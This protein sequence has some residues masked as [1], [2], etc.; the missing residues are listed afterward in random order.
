MDVMNL[1]GSL[2]YYV[3][4]R[5]YLLTLFTFVASFN[6]DNYTFRC[7]PLQSSPLSSGGT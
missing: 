4:G 7:S 2:P 6:S 5:S 3:L 1:H